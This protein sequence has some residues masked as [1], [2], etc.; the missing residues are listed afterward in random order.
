MNKQVIRGMSL[1]YDLLMADGGSLVRYWMQVTEPLP[2][3]GFSVKVLRCNERTCRL[4]G[5]VDV[6]LSTQSLIHSLL[7]VYDRETDGG[8]GQR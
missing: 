1:F 7:G 2:R 4:V 6:W 8:M 3:P 5:Y